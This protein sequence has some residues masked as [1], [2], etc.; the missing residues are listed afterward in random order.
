MDGRDTSSHVI[1]SVLLRALMSLQG[2][3]GCT[4][5]VCEARCSA[6]KKSGSSTSVPQHV[7][8]SYI[9]FARAITTSNFTH[10]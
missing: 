3:A 1:S 8:C 7:D 2:N 5:C 10:L 4:V 6:L 9:S